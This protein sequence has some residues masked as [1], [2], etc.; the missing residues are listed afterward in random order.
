MSGGGR[1]L[2]CAVGSR[3]TQPARPYVDGEILIQ[4]PEVAPKPTVTRRAAAL[5]PCANSPNPAR[6]RGR[7]RARE[8]SRRERPGRRR[9]LRSHPAVAFTEP[10]WIL[11]APGD[12]ET[13][14]SSP[15]GSFGA[16]TA[17]CRRPR[18]SLAARTIVGIKGGSLGNRR[19]VIGPWGHFAPRGHRADNAGRPASWAGAGAAGGARCR[20]GA[21]PPARIARHPAGY[22]LAPVFDDVP[23]ECG[24]AHEICHLGAARADV[25]AAL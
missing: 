14:R 16:C 7:T 21:G 25:N 12:A 23:A 13:T 22:L 1:R 3:G 5:A 17:S 19:P 9:A 10:N 2:H 11:P 6:A 18:I 15:T 20:T 24:W 8:C 4:F